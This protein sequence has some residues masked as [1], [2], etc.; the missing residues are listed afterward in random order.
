MAAVEGSLCRQRGQE[1][2]YAENQGPSGTDRRLPAN[3]GRSS[4]ALDFLRSGPLDDLPWT[5]L[6]GGLQR[7]ANLQP[8]KLHKFRERNLLEQERLAAANSETAKERALDLAA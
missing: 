3:S 4:R 6:T 5:S 8:E 1:P 2:S 7:H